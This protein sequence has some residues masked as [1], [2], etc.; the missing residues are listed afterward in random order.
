MWVERRLKIILE[1]SSAP[2]LGG[3]LILVVAVASCYMVVVRPGQKVPPTDAP[4]PGIAVARRALRTSSA[5]GPS[6][7]FRACQ[8]QVQR[9]L[10][11][12]PQVRGE[13]RS[14]W[15]PVGICRR[16]RVTSHA[17]AT[18]RPLAAQVAFARMT[19]SLAEPVLI[20]MSR[21]RASDRIKHGLVGSE[22]V[23]EATRYRFTLIRG[24]GLLEIRD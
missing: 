17:A 24:R 9:R 8:R 11:F 23:A 3:F 7:H 20:G 21:G 6:Y 19:I 10:S 1:V 22:L 16:G 5:A 18:I 4:V 12:G 2:R 13:L 15:G 14:F